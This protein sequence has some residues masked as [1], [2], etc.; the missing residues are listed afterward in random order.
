MDPGHD[1]GMRRFRLSPEFGAGPIWDDDWDGQQ[2][3]CP[4]PRSLGLS[5]QLA[6]DLD[7]WQ[8][9]YD[10]TLADYPPDSRF[11][12]EAERRRWEQRGRELLERLRRELGATAAVRLQLPARPAD[13]LG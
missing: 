2:A 9:D 11:P 8:S 4:S 6:S 3:I 13:E 12:S 1:G 10:A 7:A 5:N